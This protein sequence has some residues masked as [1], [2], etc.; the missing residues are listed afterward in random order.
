[1]LTM[2]PIRTFRTFAALTAPLSAV[3]LAQAHPGHGPTET[4]HPHGD[5]IWVGLLLALVVIVGLAMGT[6]R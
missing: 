1:M 2:T 3:T 4:A 5:S 6:R